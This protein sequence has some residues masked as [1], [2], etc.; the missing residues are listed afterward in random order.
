MPVKVDGNYKNVLV[1]FHKK[2]LSELDEFQRKYAPQMNRS[3]F[4]M[5][6]INTY[7]E[8]KKAENGK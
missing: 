5:S 7:L 8:Q 3:Q 4:I 6:I 1:T 2:V